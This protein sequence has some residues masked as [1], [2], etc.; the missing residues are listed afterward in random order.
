MAIAGKEQLFYTVKQIHDSGI[1]PLGFNGIYKIIKSKELA[2]RRVGRK[3]LIT[4]DDLI[5]F[6][7]DFTKMDRNVVSL[8]G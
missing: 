8:K 3:I 1:I 6:A 4:H 2:S 7:E 5:K